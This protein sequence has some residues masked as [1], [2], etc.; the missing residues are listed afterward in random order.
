VVDRPTRRAIETLAKSL[1]ASL[2]CVTNQPT[3]LVPSYP[4]KGEFRL[5]F[6]PPGRSANLRRTEGGP[7]IPFRVMISVST[8]STGLRTSWLK[9][10]VVSYLFEIGDNT[11]SYHWHPTGPSNVTTPH[12]H[13]KSAAAPTPLSRPIGELHLP[14]GVVSP[15]SI[16]RFLIDELGVEPNRR[17]WPRVLA[18]A[19]AAL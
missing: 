11:I 8:G 19:E 13:V 14:T 18:E 15:A 9:A 1:Q 16:I 10:S 12:A 3:R 5:E 17:D 2:Y 4:D 6:V 7:H